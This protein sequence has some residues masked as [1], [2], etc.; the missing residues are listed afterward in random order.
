MFRKGQFLLV[1][2]TIVMAM[3]AVGLRAQNEWSAPYSL[4]TEVYEIPQAS[5]K[6]TQGRLLR[7]EVETYGPDGRR[8]RIEHRDPQG[9]V[10]YT[11]ADFYKDDIVDPSS[12][13]ALDSGEFRPHLFDFTYWWMDNNLKDV[14]HYTPQGEFTYRN[15]DVRDSTRRLLEI[16]YGDTAGV[17]FAYDLITYDDWRNETKITHLRVGGIEEY[18]INFRYR[19]YDDKGRWTER[20]RIREGEPIELHIRQRY[21]AKLED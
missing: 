10:V 19:N 18:V 8:L 1:F 9:K 7:T 4:V 6:K 12:A 2:L 17:T 13:V 20:V 15:N 11:Y 14:R 5:A 3:T 16:R 21:G